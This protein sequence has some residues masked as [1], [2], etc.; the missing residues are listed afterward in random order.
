MI[1]YMYTYCKRPLCHYVANIQMMMLIPCLHDTAVSAGCQ[2]GFTTGLTTV[3][4]KQP[5]FVQP[6]VKRG[7]TTA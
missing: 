5:L 4:N 3:L 2:T 6:V 1:L 7:C